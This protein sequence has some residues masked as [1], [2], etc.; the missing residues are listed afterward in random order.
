MRKAG[1]KAF[2]TQRAGS[3]A[4]DIRL[5]TTLAQ[6]K[7]SAIRWIFCP[8][9]KRF[10]GKNAFW[11]SVLAAHDAN[12]VLL[13]ALP[14]SG[15]Y[16]PNVYAAVFA[17]DVLRTPAQLIRSLKKAG[18]GGVINLPSVSF[19]D[20]EAGVTL[21]SL[22]L[23]VDRELEFLNACAK[24]GLRIA[25]VVGS[26]PFARRL[27]SAGADFLIAHGGPPLN[28]EKNSDNRLTVELEGLARS[29]GVALISMSPLLETSAR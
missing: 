22:S 8:W 28:G 29:K 15:K 10:S 5:T 16:R 23:G 26:V 11:L 14:P 18:I 4:A 17:A 9:L 24:Q 7:P 3:R 25:G 1:T 27:L 21:N 12:G 6:A 13:E 20:G 19:I 2:K